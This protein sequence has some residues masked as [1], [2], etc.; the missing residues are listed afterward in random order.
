M[1]RIVELLIVFTALL[2]LIIPIAVTGAALY[3]ALGS[4]VF[5]RQTRVGK[6]LR[7]F[8]ILKYRTMTN[9]VDENGNL[10][11][12]EMRQTRFSKFIRRVRLD[13]LP[14]ILAIAKG[15]MALV[16]PR[17]LLP[18]T[19]ES[20][21]ELGKERCKVRPGLTGWSQVNGNVNLTNAQKLKL[22]LWYV[23][24]RSLLLDF[25]IIVATIGVVIFGE[26]VNDDRINT[27]ESWLRE[28]GL[29]EQFENKE[30]V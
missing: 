20:F 8:D 7:V 21:G 9:D 19:I 12:D 26:N 11:P 17:P 28:V 18:Q 15:D 10:L 24:H 14:Q 30:F 22:D 4:P 1:P 2:F 23:Y 25:K 29:A 16:G 6:D 13:E 27:A 5:F 3:L